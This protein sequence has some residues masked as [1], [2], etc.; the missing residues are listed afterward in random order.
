MR[1]HSIDLLRTVAIVIMVL[2]HFAENLSG[3]SLAEPWTPVR[4]RLEGLGA[5]MFAFLTG[6]SYGLWLRGMER[7]GKSDGV[8]SRVTVR[9]GL[10]LAGLGFVFNILVWLPEDTFNWDV[11]TMLGSSLLVLNL[12]RRLPL[13][14][15]LFFCVMAFALSPVLRTVADYPAFWTNGYFEPDWTLPDLAL[16][17]LATGYF[18]LFPWLIYPLVGY[19]TGELLRLGRPSATGSG[20]IRGVIL[21]G[22]AFA[23]MGISAVLLRA[24]VPGLA[25]VPLLSG[26]T[27]FP[28]SMEYVLTTLGLT[29][30]A[31]AGTWRWLDRESTPRADHWLFRVTGTFS[32]HSLTLYLLHHAVH[33]WPLWIYGYS[34]GHDPSHFWKTSMPASS[35]LLLAATFLVLAYPLLRWI[36]Q[37]RI[38]VA[39]DW[40]RWLCDD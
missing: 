16:G 1:L 20:S 30:L 15:P 37:K 40:M 7:K 17:Y 32:R 18:P 22:S 2:V 36:E 25:A 12:A 6:I 3:I 13:V 27:M 14:V 10:F 4:W 39:E 33:L 21:C 34:T 5:P 24:Y 11:L 38:P 8:I 9:R 28:P 35:A 23:L 19:A 29:L 31:F 26:W